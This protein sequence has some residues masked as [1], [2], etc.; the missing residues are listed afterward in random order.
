MAGRKNTAIEVEE[1]IHFIVYCRSKGM[2]SRGDLLRAFSDKYPD[3]TE[4]QFDYDYQKAR[5]RIREYFESDMDFQ[6]VELT[7]HLWELYSKSLKLQDYREC[8]NIIREISELQGLKVN[9][10]DLTSNGKEV[11]T[12]TFVPVSPKSE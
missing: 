4:R 1:R 10:T 8:R 3:L 7:K 2:K 11:P 6:R 12:L 9:K 5:E